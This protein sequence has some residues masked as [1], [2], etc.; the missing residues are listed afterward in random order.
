MSIEGEI[1]RLKERGK[2]LRMK[3]RKRR[4]L[5]EIRKIR[6]EVLAT[7]NRVG[8]ITLS[9]LVGEHG[10]NIGVKDTPSDKNLVKKQLDRLARQNQLEFVK[11]GRDLVAKPN[12]AEE[13]S[14]AAEVLGSEPPAAGNDLSVIRAYAV[15]VE[16]FAKTLQGQIRTLVR[17]VE[18]ATE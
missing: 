6:E 14:K 15:Q 8:Q 3:K 5:N 16:E 1:P 2:V 13:T 18:K 17:M 12:P 4:T 9:Q 7:V 10:E 11:M